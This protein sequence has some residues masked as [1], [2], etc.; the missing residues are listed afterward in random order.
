MGSPSRR[1]FLIVVIAL[2]VFACAIAVLE[3]TNKTHFF[4]RAKAV[5]STIPSQPA[6]QPPDTTTP[7]DDKNNQPSPVPTED[8]NQANPESPKQGDDTTAPPT[9]GSPPLTPT[10]D[11]ISNHSPNLSGSPAPSSVQSVCNTSPGA[12]CRIEFTNSDGIVKTLA[13][14]K[15]DTNGATYWNWDVKTAGFTVGTWTI[16]VIAELHGQT[17][18]ATEAQALKVG[19]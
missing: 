14:Q 12:M 19:P 9:T 15:T 8:D 1:P 10:G 13:A 7:S 5:S 3:V 18:T 16:K 17:T 2:A 4:H 11:F 6:H